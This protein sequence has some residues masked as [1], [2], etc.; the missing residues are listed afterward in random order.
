MGLAIGPEDEI[1]SGKTG[2]SKPA[3][4]TAQPRNIQT[5]PVLV[6]AAGEAPDQVT[7][8]AIGTARAV[9][10]VTLYPEVE[11]EVVA[12]PIQSGQR[13][14]ANQVMMKLGDRSATLSVR[15]AETRVREAKSALARADKLR[16][17]NVRSPANVEDAEVI[18]ERATLELEQAREALDDRT[19]RAPF[20]GIVGIPKIEIG[21]RVNSTMEIVTLDD[22]STLLVEFEVA[23]RYLSRLT[24]GMSL[25]ARTPTF[26][27][28]RIDGTVDEIDSRVDPV[29]RTVL[30]RA[31]FPNAEDILRPGMSFFVTLILP[32]PVMP[33]VP[34]LALQWRDG[35]SFVWKID[36][37]TTKRVD[38][39]ARRRLNDTV[40]V[41]GDIAPGDLVVVEGVQRLRDG[42]HVEISVNEGS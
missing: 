2:N 6:E 18:L 24:L 22:R 19:L 28:R 40:L 12:L 5:V 20:D 13:V 4:A 16:K 34:E 27:D 38:V 36:E 25:D 21:D 37:G 3:A 26:P 8:E 39:I 32:G 7:I 35:T 10:S 30:I 31:A 33:T 1:V 11:G 41:E 23:E 15:V 14:K 17:T 42:R 9:R 29:S